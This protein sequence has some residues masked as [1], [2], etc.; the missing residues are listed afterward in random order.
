[1]WKNSQVHPECFTDCIYYQEEERKKEKRC[2]DSNYKM[3]KH[4]EKTPPSS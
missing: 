4:K 1:M 2:S 3:K